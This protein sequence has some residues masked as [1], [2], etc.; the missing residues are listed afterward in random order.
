[1]PLSVLNHPELQS[2]AAAYEFVEAKLWPNGP[3]C[4]HCGAVG[5]A[6]ALKSKTARVGLRKCAGCRKTFTVKVG[7]IFEDSHVPM[8]KWLQAIHLM[9]SSKKGISSHQLHRILGVTLKTAWFMSHRIREAMRDGSLAALGGPNGNAVEADETFIG[10]KKDVPVPKGG[11]SHKHAVLA[12]VERGGKVRTFH[13]GEVT[14]AEIG[15][16]VARTS[17][18][19]HGS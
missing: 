12:L 5:R 10:R 17:R 7:T 19:R 2:E 18:A 4:P 14:K 11:P 13:I 15:A 8:H 16:I 9:C 1:M 6:Y 3:E